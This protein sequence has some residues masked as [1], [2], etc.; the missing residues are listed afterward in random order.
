MNA[1]EKTKREVFERDKGYC[2]YCGQDLLLSPATYS[3][4]HIDHV[5]ARAKGGADELEN[6]KLACATCNL[7]L[8][9]QNDLTTFEARKE[10]INKR[11]SDYHDPWYQK[12]KSKLRN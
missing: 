6:L 7:G 5:T 4:H 11:T 2:Q 9:R 10:Y 8:S 1:W 12:L 3:S